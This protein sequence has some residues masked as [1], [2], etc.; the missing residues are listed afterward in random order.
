M[1]ESISRLRR[2]ASNLSPRQRLKEGRRASRM[3]QPG[4]IKKYS[5]KPGKT[6]LL[7]YK[8]TVLPRVW[9]LATFSA[10]VALLTC[11]LYN[12]LRKASSSDQSPADIDL[13][14]TQFWGAV[15]Y[16]MPDAV[17]KRFVFQNSERLR[18]LKYLF[19]DA[20][21]FL[22]YFTTFLTFTT[23]PLPGA[24]SEARRTGCRP[25]TSRARAAVARPTSGRSG[26]PSS[27]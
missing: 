13:G 24:S 10:I 15:A 4:S 25:S 1:E 6:L 9:R 16:W 7:R 27:R 2:V 19:Q 21:I 20:E 12:P 18:L 23:N 26:A 3:D 8:G 5:W 11:Y 14:E 22:K 17:M